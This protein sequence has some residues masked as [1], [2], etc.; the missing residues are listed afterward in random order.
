MKLPLRWTHTR[1]PRKIRLSSPSEP[2]LQSLGLKS[3]HQ[4][5]SRPTPTHL[6][7]LLN[8]AT[9]TQSIRHATQIHTQIVINSYTTF[10]FLLSNLLTLYAKCGH[11]AKSVLLFSTTH[12]DLKT[13]V[14]WTSLITQFSH[15][16]MPIKALSLFN[17][18]RSTG[19]YPNQFTF[20]AVLPACAD[21]V[22]PFHGKQIHSLVNKQGFDSDVFVGSALVGMYAK[23]FDMVSAE[24]VFDEMPERNLVSWNSLIV[25]LLENRLFDRAV[26]NLKEVLKEPSVSPDEVTY[27]SVLSACANMVGGLEIG[28]QVHGVVVKHGLTT[29]AY[30]KNSLM[31]MY[32]KFGSFQGVDKLF[33]ASIVRDVVTW[34]VMIMSY[35]QNENFEEACKCFMAIRNEGISP[36]EVSFST[37]LHA[38]SYLAALNQGALIHNEVI[39]TGFV[40]STCVASALITMYAKCGSLTDA[41]RV[42]EDIDGRNVVCWTAIIA[43]F[44]QH[45][46]ANKVIEYF[47]SMLQEGISP[48]YIT[49]VCVLSACG[50]TGQ[51][52]EGFSY[53][54]S[55]TT[56]HNMDPGPEHYA[57]MVDLL[58]RSGRLEEAERFIELMPMKP[59]PS[60]WGALLG[61]C[62]NHGNLKMG[63]K[64]AERLLEI[65]PSNP[66]NYVILANMYARSGNLKEADGIRRLMGVNGI[67]KEPGCSWIDIKDVTFVFTVNDKSHSR[68]DEIYEIL[69]NL[70]EL[71]KKKGYVAETQYAINDVEVNKEQSLWY[72]SERLALA[73]GL[74]A[75]PTGAPIRIKKNLRT[76]GDCH[77]VMK[78]ASEIFVREI[79]VRDINR[80]HHF[81]NGSCSCRDYW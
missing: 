68:T 75:L 32:C 29:L 45:G 64:V 3:Y 9:Q 39:K 35:V 27:S 16:H 69:R 62:R 79:F 23:C 12:D 25:G 43:A 41:L 66:G 47:E 33:R 48:D 71:A 1:R 10:P 50:H 51:V 36:D 80:F 5:P 40:T 4:I 8:T 67:R 13:I 63:R 72:H 52:R 74:L 59:D 78:F 46:C 73:F 56:V 24:V 57:C 20:S 34:N 6:N 11:I 54:N 81:A 44:Q 58:G 7:N 28:K 53:Y 55:M 77:T 37:V 31:D 18:M 42:F 26:L 30:V 60:V 65:E 38:S 76:C 21:T 15:H 61:A 19:I 22:N 70:R 2:I 17:H 49:F 14:T